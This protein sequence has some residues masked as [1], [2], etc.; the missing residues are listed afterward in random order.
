MQKPQSN[1]RNGKLGLLLVDEMAT[2][3]K[4]MLNVRTQHGCD[5]KNLN[6]NSKK[7]FVYDLWRLKSLLSGRFIATCFF[8]G[9]YT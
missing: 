3:L 7:I 8:L 6:F 1:S 4:A 2:E 9:G 5:I